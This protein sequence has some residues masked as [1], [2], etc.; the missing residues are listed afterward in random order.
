MFNLLPKQE[1]QGVRVEYSRRRAVVVL[2]FLGA[3]IAIG[4]V[5]LVPSYIMASLK[6]SD[7][8]ETERTLKENIAIRG[9]SDL[10]A[11]VSTANK[12]I[13]A[14]T[15][16]TTEAA[17]SRILDEIAA[18][19]SPDIRLTSVSFGRQGK[20][21]SKTTMS[22]GGVAKDRRALSE[23]SNRLKRDEMFERADLPISSFAEEADIRFSMSITLR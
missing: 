1:K 21:Q 15:P 6:A 5:S 20:D 18:Q 16:S 19:K 9:R 7:I 12:K 8:R 13:A 4:V 2:A 14:L 17:V 23:F 10:N 22:V 3:S 11:T